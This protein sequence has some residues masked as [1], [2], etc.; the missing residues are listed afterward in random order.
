MALTLPW[1][2]NESLGRSS[3]WCSGATERAGMGVFKWEGGSRGIHISI[4]MADSC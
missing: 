4:S 3:T 1:S 2:S